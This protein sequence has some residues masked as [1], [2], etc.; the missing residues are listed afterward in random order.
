MWHVF[1]YLALLLG[2]AAYSLWRGGAPERIA[3]CS[4]LVGTVAAVLTVS[5]P[6]LR[7]IKVEWSLLAIDATI[8]AILLILVVRANRLWPMFMA[9]LLIDQVAGHV[10]RALDTQLYPFL[11]WLTASMWGYLV[12]ITLVIGTRNHRLRMKRSGRDES[13]AR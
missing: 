9:A 8:L 13:W 11:Y 2:S 3:A 1:L 5:A 10:L 12:L 4:I 6:G 7:W